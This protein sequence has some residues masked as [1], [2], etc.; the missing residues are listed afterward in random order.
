MKWIDNVDGC[1]H[2]SVVLLT[3]NENDIND[4]DECRQVV[5][6][7][8]N[9]FSSTQSKDHGSGLPSSL[10][11]KEY[12]F[13]ISHFSTYESMFPACSIFIYLH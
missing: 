13:H 4:I 7:Y 6:K 12:L 1:I 2:F 8:R 11:E 10:V 5:Q 3:R 9:S